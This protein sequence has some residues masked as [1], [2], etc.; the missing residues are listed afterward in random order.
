MSIDDQNPT[1]ISSLAGYLRSLSRETP[2]RA[3]Y[4]E[5]LL[6]EVQSGR[7]SV[8]AHELSREIVDDALGGST[9]KVMRK[10]AGG[11]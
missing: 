10:G 3:A 8:D 6:A 7:Y 4:L 9:L 11:D 2:E 1:G 5:K